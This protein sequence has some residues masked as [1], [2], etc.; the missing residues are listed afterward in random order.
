[1]VAPSVSKD[2]AQTP[3]RGITRILRYPRIVSIEVHSTPFNFLNLIQSGNA[4]LTRL[5]F[6]NPKPLGLPKKVSL[7]QTSIIA[8]ISATG[9]LNANSM[10]RYFIQCI[11]SLMM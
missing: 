1:M 2:E 7:T 6:D 3:E 10:D 5:E 8:N 11:E 4:K 9:V